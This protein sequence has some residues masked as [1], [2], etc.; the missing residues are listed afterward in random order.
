[1]TSGAMV[2]LGVKGPQDAYFLSA[3]ELTPWK[4]RYP[5]HTNYAVTELQIPFC[6]NTGY[7]RQRMT[8]KLPRAGDLLGQIYL[9]DEVAPISYDGPNVYDPQAIPIAASWYTDALGHAKIIDAEIQIGQH[10]FDKQT[11]EYMEWT[12][13]IMSPF[14]KD[15]GDM[16]GKYPTPIDRIMA[17]QNTQRLYTPFK[18][19]FCKYFEQSL[20]M[21]GLYWHDVNLVINQRPLNELYHSS[22][23][24]IG[25][26]VVPD[27]PRETYLLGLYVYLDKLERASFANGKHEYL[28]EQVQYLGEETHPAATSVQQHSIRYNHPVQEI[29]WACQRDS[30]ITGGPATGNNWFD[31][32]GVPFNESGF[33][34]PH[35]TDPFLRATILL[36]NHERTIDH[37]APYY[38]H[39]QQWEKHSRLAP[40]NR[41]IYGY[42]LGLRPENLLDTGS[43]NMSRMDTAYV[44]MTYPTGNL[45]W[46][47]RTRFYGRSRNLCKNTIGMMGIK[48]AA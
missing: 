17:G 42:S 30:V 7:G 21:V 5:R 32:T 44:R 9:Y 18:F 22:G 6:S 25:H 12:D 24:A 23:G 3:T 27:A 34:V 10:P 15:L 14:G 33:G 8:A 28:F 19:W 16:V 13:S 45:G 38:R 26:T 36:N 46:T 2:Q 37:F 4:A 47:G 39:V 1:M 31:Y 29:L 20:P 40:A 35:D 41:R 43:A 11:G 48:F